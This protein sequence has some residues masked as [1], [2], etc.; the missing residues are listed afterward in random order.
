MNEA[1]GPRATRLLQPIAWTSS[2][3]SVVT[4]MPWIGPRLQLAQQ[5]DIQAIMLLWVGKVRVYSIFQN[6][7]DQNFV[8]IPPIPLEKRGMDGAPESTVNPKML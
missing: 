5:P 3:W 6:Y 7:V 2:A 4:A 1:I 8:G